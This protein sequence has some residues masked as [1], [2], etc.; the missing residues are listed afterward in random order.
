MVGPKG[1]ASHRGPPKYTTEW[2]ITETAVVAMVVA[3]A[4]QHGVES[5]FFM[6]H[7]TRSM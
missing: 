5:R 7:R 6:S 3:P 1:G 2:G 4:E